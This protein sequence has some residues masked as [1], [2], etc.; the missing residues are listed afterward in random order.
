[1]SEQ[2]VPIFCER[3]RLLALANLESIPLC[4]SC[5]MAAVKSSEDPYVLGEIKP[6][7]MSKN[8]VKGL[9][10][11]RRKKNIAIHEIRKNA[12]KAKTTPLGG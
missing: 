4:P 12:V 3:C 7:Y 9:I 1:M 8:G 6:L 11:S 2:N 5:L 10:K